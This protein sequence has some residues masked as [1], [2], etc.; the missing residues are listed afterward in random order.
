MK[1][2]EAY[3]PFM[4][5]MQEKI[6]MSK[7]V[8]EFLSKN[9]DATTYE[10]LLNKIQTTVPPAGCVSFTEDSLLRHAQFV[11]DQVKLETCKPTDSSFLTY[12]HQ[13]ILNKVNKKSRAQL[14]KAS[15][16]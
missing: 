5:V 6:Q 12:D 8:I 10:D 4:D 2:S 14:F 15:L 3:S 13:G 1:G 11:I 9:Q 7:I 16:A